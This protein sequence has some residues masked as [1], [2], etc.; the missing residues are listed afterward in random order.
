MCKWGTTKLIRV[1]RRNNEYIPDGWHE[2]GVDACIADYVQTMNNRGIITTGCC[3]GHGGTAPPVV[4]ID[5]SSK[6]LLEAFEYNY[7]IIDWEYQHEDGAPYTEKVIEHI[8]PR[9]QILD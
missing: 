4:L 7:E 8:I 9:D 3:C 6:E 2:I 5:P 1:I